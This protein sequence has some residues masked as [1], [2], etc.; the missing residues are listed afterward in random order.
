[1]TFFNAVLIIPGN[2]VSESLGVDEM[3]LLEVIIEP[4]I[5]DNFGS[6]QI[7]TVEVEGVM[8]GLRGDTKRIL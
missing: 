6:F 8:N 1:V 2:E 5:G 7:M 4:F 3:V